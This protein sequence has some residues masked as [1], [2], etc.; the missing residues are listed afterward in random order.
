MIDQND[1][2]P[3]FY[4]TRLVK[5]GPW[6]PAR[7]YW[8]GER[9]EETGELIED[10]R[11]FCEIDGRPA[12]PFDRWTYLCGNPITEAEFNL[13]TADAAWCRENAPTDPKATPLSP[14]NIRE[15]PAPF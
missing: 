5:K 15:M 10:E 6:V 4:K 3:G 11:L 2:Q 8:Q 7:I 13:M 9:D 1:P 12:D 14:I